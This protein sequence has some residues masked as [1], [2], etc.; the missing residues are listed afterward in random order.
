MTNSL[1]IG[2]IFALLSVVFVF[3]S[4]VKKKKTDLIGWQVV[5]ISFCIFSNIALFAYSALSTNCIALI[6]NIKRS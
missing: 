2:N 1:I 4:V 3:V 6:R 5:N